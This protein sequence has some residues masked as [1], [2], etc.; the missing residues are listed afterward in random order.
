MSCNGKK[1]L[2]TTAEGVGYA[3]ALPFIAVAVVIGGTAYIIKVT[4]VQSYKGTKYVFNKMANCTSG[5]E[6]HLKRPNYDNPH[7]LYSHRKEKHSSEHRGHTS[8]YHR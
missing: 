7:R 2:K 3:L 6:P 5:E 8:K 1:A 4:A